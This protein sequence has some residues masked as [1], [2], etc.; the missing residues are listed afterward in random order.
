MFSRIQAEIPQRSTCIHVHDFITQLN[1]RWAVCVSKIED[2]I[3]FYHVNITTSTLQ[4]TSK[5]NHEIFSQ[6]FSAFSHESCKSSRLEAAFLT[7]KM[8][9]KNPTKI[10]S[11]IPACGALRIRGPFDSSWADCSD[12]WP[13]ADMNF[14]AQERHQNKDLQVQS[15]PNPRT[16]AQMCAEK[17]R[18][19]GKNL[20]NCYLLSRSRSPSQLLGG[21][22]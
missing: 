4:P 20:C 15:G 7:A 11:C 5:P 21:D 19:V 6:A 14:K 8:E 9:K 12:Q 1:V 16:P 3:H 13:S 22:L 18:S 17:P 2:I 10:K